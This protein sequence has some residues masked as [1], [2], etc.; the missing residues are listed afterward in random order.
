MTARILGAEEKAALWPRLT[1]LFP[2]WQEVEDRSV[3]KFP[4][5]ILEPVG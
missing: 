2:M 4:V 3:R 1:E 5:V